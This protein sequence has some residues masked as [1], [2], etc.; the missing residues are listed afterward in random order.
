MFSLVVALATLAVAS[1]TPY[2]ARPY[3]KVA[4][5]QT[6]YGSGSSLQVDLGYS[7]YQGFSNATAGID[8]YYGIRF[9]APPTGDLRFQAPQAPGENRSAVIPATEYAAQC[10]QSASSGTNPPM[11]R[12][13]VNASEDCLFLNVQ[14][15][16]NATG[17]LPVL[18]WIHGGG[19]GQG[20]GRQDMTPIMTT[21]G[22]NFIGVSIQY[23]LGAFGFVSSD[24]VFR[25]GAV[26]AGILD[27]H[28]AL[29]WVQQYIH[30]FNGDPTRVTIA[31]ESAGA[32]SVMLQDM[33][34]GGSLGTQLFE[35]SI[36]ASPYL[37]MQYGYKDWEPS[38]AYYAFAI[39][40]G[41]PPTTGYGAAN[42]T[43]IFECLVSK[44]IET[45]T[46]A[47]DLVSQ[48][49]S[50]GTWAFLPVTDGVFIQDLPS[51]Q[52]GRG[53]V[54]GLR[55]MSGNNA[56]EGV[57]FTPQTIDTEDDL[58]AYLRQTF[59]LFS[60][61]DIAK[62]LFYYPS[63]NASVNP[64]AVTFATSGDMGPTALNQSSVG[65]GQQQRADNIYAE[66]TFVCP[67]YWLAEAYGSSGGEGYKYQFSIAPA[68]HG[69]DVAGYFSYPG[70]TFDVDFTTAF[71]KIWG[72]YITT[73]NP[74]ISNLVANG[75]STD[76]MAINGASSWPPYS[77]A[78]PYQL[79]LNTTCPSVSASGVCG[80]GNATNTLRLVD[81]YTWEG[82]R[83]MRCDFWKS[84]GDIVP[85]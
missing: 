25:K 45:V 9:A 51:R 42:S 12:T 14:T 50:Y 53:Q 59:P 68:F 52:L 8:N 63:T 28:L 15:P 79:D 4:K 80:Q 11:V 13:Q 31:G 77:I 18:V 47:S 46:N 7:V 76:S 16:S 83:G 30:L 66:T 56:N 19:Y 22:N 36:V 72:N 39:A 38:Q 21:N 32:G 33:A 57:A 6:S 2:N 48:S 35:N 27:Q 3:T 82:G 84:V 64:D 10:L 41:C 71:Q 44:D 40:A 23:R 62:I 34:Y 1:P 69:E 75:I 55:I 65:T 29:Q 17:S 61:N 70:T 26:N 20:N 49:A 81:A 5:R 85:E 58:V 60:E 37:P 43:P 54:N 78:E 73:G 74:S 24:E 67:S